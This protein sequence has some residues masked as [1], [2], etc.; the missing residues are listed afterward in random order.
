MMTA[1]MGTFSGSERL[2][3]SNLRTG[4]LF[5]VPQNTDQFQGDMSVFEAEYTISLGV[6]FV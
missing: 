1:I 2:A 4:K 6:G 5:R 3:F